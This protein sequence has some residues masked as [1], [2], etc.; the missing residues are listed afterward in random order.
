MPAL[1]PT[2]P[3]PGAELLAHLV[4]EARHEAPPAIDEARLERELF[5]RL[6]EEPLP[7]AARPAHWPLR[8]VVAG[9][10]AAAA[11]AV[12]SKREPPPD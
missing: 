6:D 2:E 7:E 4:R 11:F 9:V 12:A 10:A 8:F 5:R 1:P 3:P